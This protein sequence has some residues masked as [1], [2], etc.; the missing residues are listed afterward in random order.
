M[1][2]YIHTINKIFTVCTLALTLQNQVFAQ[3]VEPDSILI[4]NNAEDEEIQQNLDS[5]VNIWHSNTLRMSDMVLDTIP[6]D[7][8]TIFLSSADSVYIKR[9]SEIVSPINFP[10]NK[11]VRSYIELYTLKRRDQ[12]ETMLGLSEYYFPIFEQALDANDMPLELKYLPIIESALNP[13]ARSR[14][15][16]AGLWQFMYGTGKM[17]GL[18]VNSYIDERYDPIKSTQSAVRYLKDLYSIY[19]DWHL[20]IAAY[21]CGPGNVNRAIRRTGG[22]KDFW[23]I[24][25]YLPRETR[26]YVPAFIAAAYTFNYNTEHSL[27][28]KPTMLPLASDTVMINK[29][30]HFEQVAL[31]LNCPIDVI[32]SLNPQYSR[33]VIPAVKK[34]YPLKLAFSLSTDFA[35]VEDSIYEFKRDKY[36]SNNSLTITPTHEYHSPVAPTGKEK[37]YYTVKS[38]DAVGLIAEWFDVYSSDLRYWNNIR[39]NIIRA[40]QKLIIYV[41]KNK[42]SHYKKINTMTYAQKQA[43]KGKSI[44]NN[45]PT[46]S[47]EEDPAFI[48]YT[49]RNGDN[50]WDIAKK[51]PGVSNKDIMALNNI[52]DARKISI[53]QRLKIRKKS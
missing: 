5:L 45:Q 26:N 38:G 48:Y 21:N 43:M 19:S 18:E 8:S 11:T 28:S 35:A 15:G 25:Y 3:V 12:V 2:P 42:V 46:V 9:L 24:Y 52:T 16:A 22:K 41:P 23:K 20:V 10:F 36:F 27:Y 6:I 39:R 4:E 40:G 51:Y 37:V 29:P 31:C 33:D 13:R 44:S 1:K 14:V 32:R 47:K 34:Q 30:L 53:G 49:V 7:S 50:L 17:Y